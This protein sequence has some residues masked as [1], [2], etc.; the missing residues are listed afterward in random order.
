MRKNFTPHVLFILFTF[1]C[2]RFIFHLN[3][4]IFSAE[5]IGFY[6][7]AID[8]ALFKEHL[9]QSLYYLHTQPPL[10]NLYLG[11]IFKWFPNTYNTIFYL[12]YL[13][14]GLVF[15]ISLFFLMVRLG[16][17]PVISASLVI[18]FTISP[19]VLL[20]E[21]WLFYSYP[22]AAFL[23]LSALFLHLYLSE[24]K[25]IYGFL[26]FSLLAVPV[27]TRIIFHYMWFLFFT[28]VLIFFLKKKRKEI[29]VLSCIPLMI[30][31]LVCL[32]NFVV[33]QSFSPSVGSTGYQLASMV[34]DELPK[35][36]VDQLVAQKKISIVTAYEVEFPPNRKG[37]VLYQMMKKEKTGIA[38]LDRFRKSSGGI[39]HNSVYH[40]ISRQH[41]DR[42]GLF[43]VK[44][45]P[46]IYL[47]T[48][49]RSF[50]IYCFPGP[51]D[52]P[53]INRSV[54]EN[55]ENAYNFMF[56][57]LN[58]IN[59][60]SLYS[61]ALYGLPLFKNLKWDLLSIVMFVCVAIFYSFL[62]LFSLK[63][64]WLF[65]NS[66]VNKSVDCFTLFFVYFNIIY[67][68]TVSNLLTPIANNRYRFMVDGFYLLLLGLVLTEIY[69]KLS[70]VKQ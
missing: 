15:A 59:D 28:F 13:M 68:T 22:V 16:V 25:R 2:S 70:K 11:I 30:I 5:H 44:H 24:A 65:F 50:M 6:V 60:Y 67:I 35:E 21:H 63:H 58:R 52:V 69:K 36:E 12:S 20:Y 55:Y 10:F 17:Q 34:I 27:L 26:F 1:I 57:H 61:K 3:G 45:Y 49:L 7:Q 33:F 29:L 66:K 46:H 62:F 9:F 38:V 32:K 8:P 37:T 54:L 19:A 53:F 41:Y 39:N 43:L 31:L 40:F 14:L 51:T 23:C 56:S 4:G 48:I 18:L 64:V 47:R 42:D